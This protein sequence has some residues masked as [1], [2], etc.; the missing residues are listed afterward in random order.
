M[1]LLFNKTQSDE[2]T[3]MYVTRLVVSLENT[4][5][6]NVS[7][8][9]SG[10]FLEDSVFPRS[11]KRHL[12]LSRSYPGSIDLCLRILILFLI[13]TVIVKTAFLCL[14]GVWTL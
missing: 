13:G 10:F 1:I 4:L 5:T 2:A 7:S 3:E 6:Q 11:G 8:S 9:Q 14:R 12:N